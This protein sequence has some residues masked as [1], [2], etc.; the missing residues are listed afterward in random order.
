[1]EPA[2]IGV[3]GVDHAEIHDSAS[4]PSAIRFH[5]TCAEETATQKTIVSARA[6]CLGLRWVMLSGWLS[7]C[8]GK[9]TV[10]EIRERLGQAAIVY[11]RATGNDGAGYRPAVTSN[12][13]HP[14]VSS[15]LAHP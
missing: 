12:R 1:M 13:T 3:T 7:L 14:A 2:L 15:A 6:L 11:W 9:T 10:V 5:D 8:A 4:G